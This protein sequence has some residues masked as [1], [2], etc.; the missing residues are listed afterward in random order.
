MTAK[1]RLGFS[2][3]AHCCSEYL[4]TAKDRLGFSISTNVERGTMELPSFAAEL[5]GL[6][7][8]PLCEAVSVTD[9][10]SRTCD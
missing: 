2:I 1:D 7:Y 10:D 4:L 5:E 3:S 8:S 6:L 9:L